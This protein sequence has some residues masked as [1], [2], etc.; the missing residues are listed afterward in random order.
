MKFLSHLELLKAWDRA[1]R[2][3]G[4]PLVFSTGYSPRPLMTFALPSAVGVRD[5]AGYMDVHVED[6]FDPSRFYY[7]T[8]LPE[9][10][11]VLEAKEVEEV[12][13]SL[14]SRVHSADYAIEGDIEA[15]KRLKSTDPLPFVRITKR[16]SRHERDARDY[17][18]D[19]EWTER[20]LRV[21]LLAGSEQS[22]RL[23]EFIEALTGD[24]EAH[25]TYQL[26]RLEIYD[27]EGRSL[28]EP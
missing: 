22:I 14:M 19:A 23:N 25:F 18:L 8:K 27:K 1:M 15:L 4:I 26:T 7:L 28:W 2:R 24:P 5:M 12:R 9:G 10:L 3:E 16:G 13:A 21:R 11:E 17:L 20:V 6:G